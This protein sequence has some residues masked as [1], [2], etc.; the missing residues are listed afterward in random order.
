MDER[1]MRGAILEAGRTFSAIANIL[2]FLPREHGH[3]VCFEVLVE[4]PWISVHVS[5]SAGNNVSSSEKF[6]A[7]CSTK[8]HYTLR[9]LGKQIRPHILSEL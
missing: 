2:S 7:G 3:T 5:Y 1:K 8:R 6:P 9:Q 4:Q